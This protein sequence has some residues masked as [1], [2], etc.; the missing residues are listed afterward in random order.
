LRY[1]I[2]ND[3]T[4]YKKIH[5][6]ARKE[7]DLITQYYIYKER[8]CDII[9]PNFSKTFI[10]N[11]LK[12]KYDQYYN[13][14]YRSLLMLHLYL[15]VNLQNFPVKLL[16]NVFLNYNIVVD[17]NGDIAIIKP[18]RGNIM[19]TTLMKLVK[20]KVDELYQLLLREIN[21]LD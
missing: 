10:L 21:K 18:L 13:N 1:F 8:Q 20:N 3:D 12:N 19:D 2:I 14:N 16:Q 6:I 17:K 4:Q 11:H 5:K 9:Q 7:L 15:R